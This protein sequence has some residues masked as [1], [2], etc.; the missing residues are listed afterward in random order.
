[1]DR[2]LDDFV[3]NDPNVSSLAMLA[4]KDGQVVYSH[5]VAVMQQVELGRLDIDQDV[6]N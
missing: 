5:A 6:G 3:A 2:V 4:V 1:M